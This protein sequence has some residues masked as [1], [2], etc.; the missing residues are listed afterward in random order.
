MS[1]HFK[2]GRPTRNWRSLAKEVGFGQFEASLGKGWVVVIGTEMVGRHLR[3]V[4]IGSNGE[5]SAVDLPH[6]S[7]RSRE[8]M[9]MLFRAR[10]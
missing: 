1:S 4:V 6:H 2:G 7:T 10:R 3:F 8:G 5:E 9:R